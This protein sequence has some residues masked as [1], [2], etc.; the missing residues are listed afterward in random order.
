M[1]RILVLKLW[2]YDQHTKMLP[3]RFLTKEA[4]SSRVR[5][6]LD[7]ELRLRPIHCKAEFKSRLNWKMWYRPGGPSE[8]SWLPNTREASIRWSHHGGS[9]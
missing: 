7:E 6:P 3:F 9:L 1:S 2:Y 8:E 5:V 4:L